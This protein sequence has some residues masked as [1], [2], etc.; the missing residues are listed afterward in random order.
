VAYVVEKLAALADPTRLAVFERVARRPAAVHEIA[1][2]FPVSRPAI[3]QHLRVLKD[4]RLVLDES[5]GTQRIYRVNPSGIEEIRSYFDRFWGDALSSF[6][7]FIETNPS[8]NSKNRHAT[9][10]RTS[11]RSKDNRRRRRR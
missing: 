9:D 1:Q 7:T 10:P 6:K 5:V 4:A 8:T 3:S 11:R 2:E